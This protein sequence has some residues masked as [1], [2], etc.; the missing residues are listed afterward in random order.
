MSLSNLKGWLQGNYRSF[1]DDLDFIAPAPHIKEQAV[2]RISQIKQQS[3][4]CLEKGFCKVCGCSVTEKV[5][6][7][8]ECEGEPSCYPI[9]FTEKEWNTYKKV[10]NIK[11]DI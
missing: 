1:M 5:W 9:M 11:V 4:T 3:P 10:N 2:W 6:E 7:D 8:R